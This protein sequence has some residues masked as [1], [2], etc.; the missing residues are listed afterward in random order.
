MEDH[1]SCRLTHIGAATVLLEIGSMRL[2]TDPV[3]DPAGGRYSFGWGTGSTKLEA[4]AA[5]VEAIGRIDAVLLSH[6][7]HQDNLDRAGRALLPRAGRVITTVPGARRLGGNAEGLEPWASVELVGSDGLRVRVMAT[8]ARHGPPLSR[9]FVG[10]VVG[11]ML[12]WEGQQHGALYI[13]GDTVWFRGVA[14]VGRRFSVGTALLHLGGVR[15]P[16]Y[17]PVRFTFGGAGAA[18]A[19]RALAPHTVVPIHYDGWQHF[20]ES[21]AASERAFSAAGLAERVVWLAKGVATELEI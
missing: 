21:R 13:S 8:P 3:F 4:P 1:V 10:Q 19:V 17:G 20:R 2:L 5:Q 6:D 11:F 15:F 9:P 12:E 16:L 7:Q 14:E 18:K